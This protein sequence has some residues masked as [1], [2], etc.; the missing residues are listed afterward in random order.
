MSE[1]RVE[2]PGNEN[3]DALP[4]CPEPVPVPPEPVDWAGCEPVL[5]LLPVLV[6]DPDPDEELDPETVLN[7]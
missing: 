7:L 1:P 2:S 4:V 3:R 5:V 6:L